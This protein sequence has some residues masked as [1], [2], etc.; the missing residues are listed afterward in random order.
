MSFFLGID[1]GTSYFKTGIFDQKGR[2]LGLGRQYVEKNT[3]GIVCE[4]SVPVFQQTLC[5]CV[6]QA[7]NE[8]G[9]PKEKIAALSYSSQAN[10]FILLDSSD[11]PLTPLILWP[12]ERTGNTCAPLQSLTEKPDFV[13]RTGL[14][15][16]PG[17]QSMIAKIDWFQKNQPDTWNKVKAVMSIS[18]YLVFLLTNK[19]ISD[20][21]TSSM[22]G[23]LDIAA[24]KWSTKSA[25]IFNIDIETLSVPLKIGSHAG[26]LTK[27]GANLLGLTQN[28]TLFLGGL[29]HHMVAVGAGVPHYNYISESTG[30]VLACVNY[31]DGYYPKKGINIAQGLD[32]NHFFQMTFSNNGANALEW[33]QKNY[34]SDLSIT[35]LLQQAE[36]I[37]IGSEGL[38]AKPEV[39]KF[40][41]LHGFENIKETH[42][43][44]HFVRSILESTGKSLFSLVKSLDEKSTSEG[45]VP[46]G[47][48]AKS[49]LWLQIKANLLNKIFL[50]PESEELACKGAAML[51][52]LGMN[53]FDNFAEA[54][55]EQVRFKEKIYPIATNA[56]NYKKWYNKTND[57]IL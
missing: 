10:S 14:G 16:L 8:S 6:Q 41:G 38:L 42:K 4:L 27:E 49:M 54:I 53:C 25:D 36:N 39:D 40:T 1:L 15:I 24:G 17:K 19:K 43:D 22:T 32:E 23:L 55:Q 52:A 26:K 28:T 48:G 51:C 45:I 29:D 12:D 7:L 35:E 21:S 44:A 5:N 34:A 56:E 3:D 20:L 50:V 47:G 31:Q 57:S 18:D 30:T 46:S 9:I 2:L 13:T 11:K 37:E 33:Y